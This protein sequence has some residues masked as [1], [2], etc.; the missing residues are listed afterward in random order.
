MVGHCAP[1][2]LARNDATNLEWYRAPDA[3]VFAQS[4]AAVCF[5]L[6]ILQRSNGSCMRTECAS[7]RNTQDKNKTHVRTVNA[8]G[9]RSKYRRTMHKG[10]QVRN[11]EISNAFIHHKMHEDQ[12]TS[13]Q[14]MMIK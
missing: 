14:G 9:A 3:H 6:F 4:G 12:M 2:D 1:N 13:A 5:I 10:R 7:T 11:R 8:H